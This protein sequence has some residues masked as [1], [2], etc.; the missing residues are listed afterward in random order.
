[1]SKKSFWITLS[2]IVLGLVDSIVA[3]ATML[4]LIF[5]E[6]ASQSVIGYK[7]GA[8]ICGAL[9]LI[10]SFAFIVIVL[11]YLSRPKD[12]QHTNSL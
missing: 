3:G 9:I 1:M 8:V 4:I 12:A 2:V 5:L 7:V 11:A 10:L 6:A